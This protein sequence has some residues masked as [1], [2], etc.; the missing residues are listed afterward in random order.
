[1]T[2]SRVPSRRN[3]PAI[4]DLLLTGGMGRPGVPGARQ[5]NGG[6]EGARIAPADLPDDFGKPPSQ[7]RLEHLQKV[8]LKAPG[9]VGQRFRFVNISRDD[10]SRE[11]KAA[12]EMLENA[13]VVNRIRATSGH[14]LPL[15]VHADE[16]KFKILFLDVG[17]MQHACGLD[18]RIALAD[19]FLSIQ[20]G[21]VAEQWVGQEIFGHGG[22]PRRTEVVLL[23]KGQPGQPGGRLPG[24]AGRRALPVE[25][26]AG[27]TGRL[28]SLKL[29]LQEH[30]CPLG[31]G[32]PTSLCPCMTGS[33]P[34]PFMRSVRCRGGW[35]KPWR[36]STTSASR[37]DNSL[38]TPAGEGDI[39]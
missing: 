10:R 4:E 21:A 16:E 18:S 1:M 23:G 11:L 31:V 24:P 35:T 13:R 36:N 26:K 12:L 3:H 14:G 27:K 20:A 7:A 25:V 8:F 30:G 34:S 6:P 37:Y 38:R 9:L 22:P 5:P 17:L 28:R 15:E 39:R 29:Y 32:S 33:C 2:V 19:D